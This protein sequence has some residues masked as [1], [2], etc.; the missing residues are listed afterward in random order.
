MDW[1]TW[2]GAVC[3]INLRQIMGKRQSILAAIKPI[4]ANSL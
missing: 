3:D 2:Y 4:S 1:R